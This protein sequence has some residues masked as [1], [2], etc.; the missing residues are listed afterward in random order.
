[1][2]SLAVALALVGC[3]GADEPGGDVGGEGLSYVR[4]HLTMTAAPATRANPTGGELGDGMEAGQDY[5]NAVS[6]AVAFFFTGSQ[7][8]NSPAATPIQAVALF[9]S[10]QPS[11]PDA[12][13]AS[14]VD[15]S[16]TSA[17]MLVNVGGGDYNVIV[18]AN[19]GSVQW[20][21]DAANRTLGAVRDHIYKEA[22]KASEGTY[23]DFVMTSAADASANLASATEENPAEVT[24]GLE[25]M[26]ARI[27]YRAK[28]TYDVSDP[29][30]AGAT[31]EIE[32][33][34]IVNSLTAGSY[35]LKRVAAEPDAEGAVVLGDETA[36]ATGVPTNYVIDPWTAGKSADNAT[37]TVDGEG[38]KPASALYAMWF[39]QQDN[40]SLQDLTELDKTSKWASITPPGTD[41][42][43]WKRVGYTLENT[44]WT[45]V[46]APYYHTGVVF[47]AL[48]KPKGLPNYAD[49]RTF[50]RLRSN[51]YASMEDMMSA[52]YGVDF[53]RF[54][55]RIDA[56]KSWDDVAD[57]ARQG[58]LDD[59]PSGYRAYL[60]A[61]ADKAGPLD[62]A[63]KAALKWRAYMLA[64]CGYSAST[65]A[66][67]TWRVSIDNGGKSTRNVLKPYGVRTYQDSQCY[68]T[69][70]V[71]HGNDSDDDNEA[72]MEHA[73]V[74]N[75]IY[76]LSVESITSIGGD[77]PPGDKTFNVSVYVNDWLVLPTEK[78]MM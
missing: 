6:S 18:V 69:W 59:D 25:R 35:L 77:I 41:I 30:Y 40:H 2:A 15:R 47:R 78:I 61:A 7:G 54:D 23:S 39:G 19:P 28:A 12:T 74:R 43:G 51:L 75:N 64:E 56:C 53:A 14:G 20:W 66:D 58:L 42:G 60:E 52:L 49:G 44:A 48:F 16:Y 55:A 62:E 70:W 1:M 17:P 9:S 8:V 10:F 27:D 34:T 68:Y 33:A 76:K 3:S 67:G 24:V 71:R 29:A 11:A 5:E 21:Q 65:D 26:A 45:N 38:G 73:I 57:F 46:S 63:A 36:T 31:V 4:L 37:F 50:F 72:P 13:L 32:G 22:W